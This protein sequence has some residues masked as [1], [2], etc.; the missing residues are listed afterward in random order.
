MK[1]IFCDFCHDVFKL[2]YEL[3]SCK[4]GKCCGHYDRDGA[5][6]VTN[7]EGYALAIGNGSLMKA[8][9]GIAQYE[10]SSTHHGYDIPLT[11]FLAWVRPHEGEENPRGRVDP[12]L[13]R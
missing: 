12:E 4:C 3:R 7:G 10:Y 1:L 5:H 2:D 11:T 8:M 13:G 9:Q 6:A